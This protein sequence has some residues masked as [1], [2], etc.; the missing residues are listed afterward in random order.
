MGIVVA[1]VL[2]GLLSLASVYQ[3]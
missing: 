1:Q 3:L 2:N